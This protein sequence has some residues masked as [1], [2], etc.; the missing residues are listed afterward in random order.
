[1][2]VDGC[3]EVEAES[4]WVPVI[5]SYSQYLH[6]YTALLDYPSREIEIEMTT[7]RGR[8]RNLKKKGVRRTRKF[9]FSETMPILL[10]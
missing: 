5:E 2:A 7:T 8:S 3:E 9:S 1:M 10:N 6:V 4:C